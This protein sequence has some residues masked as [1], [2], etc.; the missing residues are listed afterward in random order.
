[1]INGQ[2]NEQTQSVDVKEYLAILWR[3]KWLVV[4][5]CLISLGGMTAYLFS[6]QSIWRV[7]A[8]LL[9]TQIGSG[10]TA[11]EVVHEDEQ[12]FVSTQIEVMLGPTIMRRIQQRMKKT[13]EQ[14]QDNI[15]IFKV[16]KAGAT[17]ILL[18]TVESPAPEFAREFINVLVDEYLK[19][20]EKQRV[21]SA[22][23]AVQMLTRE[24]DRLGVEL[25]SANL[26]LFNFT[27]EHNV[28]D[29]LIITA[30]SGHGNN[31]GSGEDFFERWRH[32]A[33]VIMHAGEDLAD[34]VARKQLLDAR[35]NASAVLALLADERA[36][37]AEA[38][39][40][41]SVTTGEIKV[42]Q[43]VNISIP[44]SKMLSGRVVVSPEWIIEY[45]P[46]GKINVKGFTTDTLAA[47]IQQDLVAAS[48]IKS[49][50]ANETTVRVTLSSGEN[51]AVGNPLSANVFGSSVTRTTMGA[52]KDTEIDK[53]FALDRRRMTAQAKVDSLRRIYRA[54]HPALIPAEQELA[55]ATDEE[56]A[57]V[58]FYRQKADA[59]VLICERKYNS[60]QEA[61]KQ[62][63]S[64]ALLKGT[65]LQ[66]VRLLREDADRI[67]ELY[68]TMLTQLT[69]LDVSQGFKSRTV[70]ILE[71]PYVEPEPIY[72]KKGKLM[73]MAG[74]LGIGLGGALAFFLVYID[75]PV[76][77]AESFE[78]DLQLPFLGMIPFASWSVDDLTFHRLDR[79]SQQSVTTEAYGV[80]R[81]ALMGAIPKEKLHAI[82][83]SSTAPG[84]G[85]TTTAVNLA[86][87]FAHIDERVLL[88]DADLRRGEIHKF[89]DFDQGRGLTE[90]LNGEAQPEEARRHTDIHKLD[91]IT[92]GA[93]PPNPA[94]LLLSHRL[95]EFLNWARQNYD[96]ILI[97]GPPITGVADSA[98][99]NTVC[100][101][102]LFIVRPGRTL[103]NY[104][105]QAKMTAV[106]RGANFCGF[107]LNDLHPGTYPMK[108]LEDDVPELPAKEVKKI[109]VPAPS[110]APAP[111]PEKKSDNSRPGGIF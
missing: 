4:F 69:K 75:D 82:L 22:E 45:S 88:I 111:V 44:Q 47:K 27:K 76:K 97:D 33:N 3:R 93:Y 79:Y 84:E 32:H 21:A 51:E 23:S 110:A 80:I 18:I 100:D 2:E 52:L 83:I 31:H 54:K 68:N 28:A 37:A 66:E 94:E 24:I 109:A 99:L 78:R 91:V 12:R 96:R 53:L 65:Q 20:R 55:T 5:C 104:V 61:G 67:R 62:L 105:R 29:E 48:V 56:E 73:L 92:T 11:S 49:A 34:A 101:D 108:R 90:I 102:V 7:N 106:S 16:E 57:T 35:P 8:K 1:M 63:E 98:I 42:G 95:R 81:S 25:K 59:E 58:T 26:K 43:M 50:A 14:I 17:D 46:L 71:T 6:R 41:E 85:K 15:K 30:T 13:T 64:E 36:A 87:S 19:F 60:L 72:P 40:A 39:A 107:I 86:I 10:V 9:I 70:S 74:F 77:L 89:F 103:R 38:R